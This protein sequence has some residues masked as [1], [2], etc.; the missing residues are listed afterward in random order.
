MDKG[1]VFQA[2]V[3]EP[4]QVAFGDT[5]GLNALLIFEFQIGFSSAILDQTEDLE[6]QL[7]VLNEATIATD[8]LVLDLCLAHVAFVLDLDKLNFNNEAVDLEV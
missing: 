3:F 7:W 2:V 8:L 5:E 1:L 4:L 6:D